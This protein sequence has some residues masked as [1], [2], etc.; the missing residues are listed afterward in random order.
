MMFRITVTIPLEGEK[1][2]VMDGIANVAKHQVQSQVGLS[3]DNNVA[4]TQQNTQL[5]ESSNQKIEDANKNLLNSEKDVQSLVENLNKEIALLN[6]S[7]KFGVDKQDTFYVS[8]IDKK[9]DKVIRRWPAEEA[10]PLL[11]KM[12]EFTGI[13]FDKKG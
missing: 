5:Q 4:N 13:L 7:L 9:T 10:Q 1:E 11:S 8:V 2:F 3:Q 6:T 12:K